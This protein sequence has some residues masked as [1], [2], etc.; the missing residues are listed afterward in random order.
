MASDVAGRKR[1]FCK[2]GFMMGAIAG[3]VIGSVHESTRKKR[4]DFPLFHPRSRYTAD[5]VLTVA[6]ASAILT[7][8][9]YGMEYHAFGRR[10]PNAGYGP[11]FIEWLLS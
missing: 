2:R 8:T 6:T 5:A 9:P 3:D 11:S 4:M 1:Q 10:Y 7:D